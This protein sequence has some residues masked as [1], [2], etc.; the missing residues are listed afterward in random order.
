MRKQ[1][2][3]MENL[4]AELATVKAQI[5]GSVPK[6]EIWGGVPLTL[7]PSLSAPARAE[8][9]VALTESP[10]VRDGERRPM[11][12]PVDPAVESLRAIIRDEL[13]ADSSSQW[14]VEEA[15]SYLIK[16]AR[17]GYTM[18]RQGVSLAIERLHPGFAVKLAEAVSRA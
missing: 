3:E 6:A 1:L 11:L 15:K 10:N 16:T 18:M 17:P 8:V 2:N 5:Q 14:E 13:R 9:D 4:R 12:P 7:P